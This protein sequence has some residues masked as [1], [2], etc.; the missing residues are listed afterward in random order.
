MLNRNIQFM[1]DRKIDTVRKQNTEDMLR[2]RTAEDIRALIQNAPEHKKKD[3]AIQVILTQL[4]EDDLL[5]EP[6][7]TRVK[8]R[9]EN[10]SAFASLFK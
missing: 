8:R 4:Q 3:T 2:A 5:T 10:N 7:L 9:L 6:N 1:N